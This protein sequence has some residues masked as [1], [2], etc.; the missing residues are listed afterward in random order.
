MG[1]SGGRQI[2]GLTESLAGDG[3]FASPLRHRSKVKVK[4][5][6][7]QIPSTKDENKIVVSQSSVS[8]VL[9]NSSMTFS[10]QICKNVSVRLHY[11][12]LRRCKNT[13]KN[14]SFGHYSFFNKKIFV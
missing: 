2:G 10:L 8:C 6:P 7:N 3:E 5:V 11:F 4:S 9:Y 13:Q 14:N 12:T 1:A